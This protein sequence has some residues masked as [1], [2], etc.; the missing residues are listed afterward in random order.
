M[1]QDSIT[2]QPMLPVIDDIIIDDGPVVTSH[3]LTPYQVLRMLPKDATPAQQDSAIQAWFIPGAIAYSQQPDTLHLPGHEPAVDLRIV[4]LPQYYRENY[5]SGDSLYHPEVVG[6]RFGV[7]GDP[8][9]Y[10]IRGDNMF[11][12]LLLI[13]FAIFIVS[14]SKAR[15]IIG[16]QLRHFFYLPHGIDDEVTETGGELRF[17]LFLALLACLL[18]AITTY[19][20]AID[21]VAQTFV[22][23][24][25]FLL[26]MIFLAVF[27]AYFV[28]KGGLYSLVNT[29]FF[30]NGPNRQ[31]LKT[32]LFIMATEGVLLF[33]IVL[34]VVY[35]DLPLEKAAYYYGFVFLF[36]KILAFYKAW[37]I[38]FWQNG[39]FLQIFLYF[40]ALE[41]VPL[42]V[43]AGS[44]GILMEQ[45]KITF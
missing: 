42:L 28:L 27:V 12:S 34:L 14:L 30:G 39:L 18:M 4:S 5:F 9:P 20:Y 24:N 41:I 29:V 8:V 15:Y 43:L 19:Q 2:L 44:L 25:D 31:W 13:C 21:F 10:T 16:R 40:C 11:T 35:F 38:F 6:G 37:S 22:L 23:P 17:Q 32:L 33:P 7:A 36:T 1:T 26:V 3:P 45:L